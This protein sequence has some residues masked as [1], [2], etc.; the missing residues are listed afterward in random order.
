LK[1]GAFDEDARAA[2]LFQEPQGED[3]GAGTHGRR[4]ALEIEFLKDTLKNAPRPKSAIT[5]ATPAVTEGD[6]EKHFGFATLGSFRKNKGD[7]DVC[8]HFRL[9]HRLGADLFAGARRPLNPISVE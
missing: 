4:H 9:T 5:F 2:D 1:T 3:R 6:C 8:R 7:P